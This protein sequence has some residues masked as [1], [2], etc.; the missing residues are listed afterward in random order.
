MVG[1]GERVREALV[2]GHEAGAQA[3]CQR[4][5]HQVV[6]RS[7]KRNGEPYG[8]CAK[9]LVGVPP[10]WHVLDGGDKLWASATLNLAEAHLPPNRVG[11][12][13]GEEARDVE[14]LPTE[15]EIACVSR[16]LLYNEPLDRDTRIDHQSHCRSVSVVAVFAD[17][18]LGGGL[19]TPL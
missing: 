12:F 18:L 1:R 13:G 6:D 17:E 8:V 4:E 9:R 5:I 10:N 16:I 3:L 11:Y 19:G 15:E 2:R 14:F 7:I